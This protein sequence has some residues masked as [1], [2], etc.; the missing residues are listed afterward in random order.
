MQVIRET[1]NSHG[2]VINTEAIEAP[3]PSIRQ[4]IKILEDSVSKNDLIECALGLDNGK[5]AD[6][7]AKINTLKMQL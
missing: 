2:Q 4:Q 5:V 7:Y 1:Y 3:A 6:I